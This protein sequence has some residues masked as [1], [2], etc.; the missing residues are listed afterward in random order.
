M[1]EAK[2]GRAYFF[3]AKWSE[4]RKRDTERIFAE[5]ERKSSLVKLK[6]EEIRLGL[7]ARRVENAEKLREE[8]F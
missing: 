7:V 4:L 5:L 3:E 6:A 8:G 2:N 1:L